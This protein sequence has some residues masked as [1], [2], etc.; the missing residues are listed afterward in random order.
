LVEH[1]EKRH[2]KVLGSRDDHVV[3]YGSRG[4]VVD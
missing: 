2:P 3:G 4:T 1:P